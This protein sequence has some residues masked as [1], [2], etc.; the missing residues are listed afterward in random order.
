MFIPLY[1]SN[2]LRY[3]RHQYVTLAII[4]LNVLIYLLISLPGGEFS[5]AATFGFGYI[6]SVAYNL[7][8]LPPELE[9]V[10]APLTYVTYA[11]MHGSIL[12]L[13]GNMLFLWVFGDNVEDALGHFR[14]L[15]FYLACT[16][17]GAVVHGM[18]MPWSQT[19]LIGAS[20]AVAGVVAAY[21]LLH[22]RVK[23]WVL[24]FA[25][26]PLRLPAYIVLGMWIATQFLMMA[27]DTEGAI[28]W[29]A[30]IGGIIAGAI[31][32]IPLRRPG[33]PLFEKA[34]V[35]EDPAKPE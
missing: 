13:A 20:G 25:R 6:P 2:R 12:H 30:H 31:L 4:G 9:M 7:A 23:L 16:I 26:I 8:I 28:S 5:Q 35:A 32:I 19:P 27:F 14:F 10:P 22:P 17:A 21:C 18:V 34:V 11:F 15:I 24:M 33:V 3:I 29:A 1:D